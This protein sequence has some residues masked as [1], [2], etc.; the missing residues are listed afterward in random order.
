MN[1]RFVSIVA[2]I[3][4]LACGGQESEPV[5]GAAAGESPKTAPVV[6]AARVEVATIGLTNATINLTRPGEVEA[7][8]EAHVASPLGGLVE[9]VLVNSG[10]QV[11]VDQILAKVDTQLQRAN[12]EVLR[13]EVS[14]ST[15]EWKRLQSMGDS[16]AS[17]KVDAAKTRKERAEAQLQL[18]DLM[19]ER[20][21]IRAPF[22][23]TIGQMDIEVGEVL[24]PSVPFLRLLQFQPATI[25]VSVADRDVGSLKVD[26]EARVTAAGIPGGIQGVISEI[27]PVAN[28]KTRTFQAKVQVANED[29]L[30]LPGMIARVDFSQPVR[31]EAIVLPQS[32][33]VTRLNENGVYLVDDEGFARWQPLELGEIIRDQVMVDSGLEPGMKIVTL[34]QRSLADGDALIIEREGQC[35]ENG[36][37]VFAEV[38]ATEP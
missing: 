7:S 29:R 28:L 27:D 33:L 20:S 15:R 2:S 21:L 13:I 26:G 25:S 17:A 11:E 14:E 34:G 23:G 4:L 36:R 38:E 22:S 32:M 9:E 10:D 37:V 12:A 19:V 18:A 1:L 6:D 16:V 24:A 31:A 30:L 3:S 8:R 5:T 35:C